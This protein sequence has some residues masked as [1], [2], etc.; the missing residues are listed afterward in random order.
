MIGLNKGFLWW[1]VKKKCQTPAYDRRIGL[2][3]II[4]GY[5]QHCR[6]HYELAE[7]LGVSEETLR[8]ALELYH[9]KYGCYTPEFNT[10][11]SKKWLQVQ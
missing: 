10:C 4:Q 6:N 11:E 8:D 3:G 2:S 9:E 7:C 5:R 1:D